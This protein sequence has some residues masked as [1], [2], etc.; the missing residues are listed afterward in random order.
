MNMRFTKAVALLGVCLTLVAA[1][2]WPQARA[3]TPEDYFAFKVINDVRL[4]PDGATVAFVLGTVDQKQNRRYNAIWTVPIDGSREALP[5]TTSVQ[6]STSP[7]WNPDGRSIAF[8]SARPSPG[9][10]AGETPRNQVWLLSLNGGEPRRLTSL[11]NGVSS[12]AWSTDGTRLVCVSS[13]G[14]SDQAKSPSDVRHS[15]GCSVK[16]C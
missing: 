5:L 10:A 6:S 16:T 2:A 7:R 13:S 11:K 9:D 4:S 1:P 14:P 3:V 15:E 12:F 8:L